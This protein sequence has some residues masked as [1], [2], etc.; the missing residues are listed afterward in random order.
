[1][2]EVKEM[3]DR[4]VRLY[5]LAL[6]AE[7][8]GRMDEALE[9]VRLASEALTHAERLAAQTRSKSSEKIH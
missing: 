6:E 9:L 1:M 8:E 7:T 5:A 4:A 2:D 3:H